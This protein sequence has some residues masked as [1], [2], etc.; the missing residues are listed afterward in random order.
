MVTDQAT[1]KSLLCTT[2]EDNIQHMQTSL[3]TEYGAGITFAVEDAV[4]GPDVYAAANSGAM[5]TRK[6]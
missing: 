5:C 6:L 3:H 1:V 4:L 2:N